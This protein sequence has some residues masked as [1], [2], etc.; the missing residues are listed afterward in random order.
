MED[1]KEAKLSS[2]RLTSSTHRVGPS[3]AK[4]SE[5]L[6]A[7]RRDPVLCLPVQSG[8][9]SSLGQVASG[10]VRSVLAAARSVSTPPH[11][12]YQRARQLS[13]LFE[14]S[15]SQ[16]PLSFALRPDGRR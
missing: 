12:R 2:V 10:E 13:Q 4:R 1:A 16:P 11:R 6:A 5:H 9:V 3:R 8:P 7:R 15:L 14:L